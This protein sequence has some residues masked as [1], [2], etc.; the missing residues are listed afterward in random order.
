M[1]EIQDVAIGKVMMAVTVRRGPDWF[2]GGGG[3]RPC[4]LQ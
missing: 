3:E 2:E 4:I 1:R